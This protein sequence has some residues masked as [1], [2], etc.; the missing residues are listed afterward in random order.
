MNALRGRDKFE[1]GEDKIASGKSIWNIPTAVPYLISPY[2]L[3]GME[4][5]Q[6]ACCLDAFRYEARCWDD[7]RYGTPNSLPCC[8][9][10]VI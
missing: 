8:D 2:F 5:W 9:N 7:F 3:K 6:D 10:L 4:T 1:F